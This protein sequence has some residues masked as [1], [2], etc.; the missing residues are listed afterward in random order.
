MK[1]LNFLTSFCIIFI[2]MIMTAGCKA[3]GQGSA[4]VS[5]GVNGGGAN[6]ASALQL[7][8]IPLII[9][10]SS[11]NNT[12][13]T[14]RVVDNLGNPVPDGAV[15]NFSFA[16]GN[17][18]KASL[19]GFSAT[20]LGG[21]AKV[22]VTATTFSNAI[23]VVN[24]SSGAASGSISI[25]IKAGAAGGTVTVAAA[26]ANITVTGTSTI[27]ATVK[28]LLGNTVAAGVNVDFSLNNAN[29]SLSLTTV[30][31]NASGQAQTVLTG[32]ATPN[33]TVT[34]TVASMGNIQGAATVTINPQ[35]LVPTLTISSTSS[36]ILTFA[37]TTVDV[38]LSGF[39]PLIGQTVFF[40]VDNP[41]VVTLSAASA[42][43]DVTGRASITLTA[44]GVVTSVKVTASSTVPGPTVLNGFTTVS[45]SSAP[46]D[47]VV[48]IANPPG[49]TVF[50][51][52]TLSA[53]VTGN[54]NTVP[55][56]TVVNFILSNSANGSLS[57]SNGS[58]VNG[59]ATTTFIATNKAGSVSITAVAGSVSS[60]PATITITPATT[61]S[62]QFVSATPQIIGLK[63]SGN[64]VSTVVFS[65]LDIAGRIVADGTQ[66]TF[67]LAA[68]PGG[69]ACIVGSVG[70][71]STTS[72]I[73]STVS[74]LARVTL[75]SGSTAGPV[76][77]IATTTP[78][79]LPPISTSASEIS[80]GGGVVSATHF[81]LAT[82]QFNLPGFGISN[83]QANITAYVADRFG[84]F[85]ILKGTTVSFQT[86]AGAIDRA[87]TTDSTGIT[88]PPVV[89]RTQNP[90]PQPVKI[91]P[92]EVNL[93]NYLNR[94]Y[95]LTGTTTTL[96]GPNLS[97]DT[98]I[99]VADTSAFL[100]SGWITIGGE[101]ILYT[102]T[103]GLSFTGCT[104]GVFGTTAA[105]HP[106]LSIV[107]ELLS[108]NIPID[109]SAGHPRNGLVTVLATVPG[110]EAFSDLNGN[111][112][113]DPGEPFVDIGEPL[114]DRNGDGCW[115]KGPIAN[116]EICGILS[117][118]TSSTDPF[119][120]YT[121]TNNNGVWDPPNGVWDGPGCKDAG[122]QP[123][124][125]IWDNMT[126]AFTGGPSYCSITPLSIGSMPFG[127]SKSFS[128]MVGDANINALIPGT[129]IVAVATAGTLVGET[130]FTLLDGVP[131]GPAETFFTLQASACSSPPCQP[132]PTSI[133]ITVTPPNS[134]GECI[135]T[136][137]GIF[138]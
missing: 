91:L 130:S 92:W 74:G 138:N 9:D 71:C 29:G 72:A 131:H 137:S 31:T 55:D 41:G 4:V 1:K 107:S 23:V 61:G 115:N 98:I 44:K 64:A 14:A 89:F 8:A 49:I 12:V 106:D 68:G 57:S 127:S 80:I 95:S 86:D 84:N 52:S 112:L 48:L 62:I 15:V 103:T 7:T 38:T 116:A 54:S 101:A 35:A 81:T 60:S 58:T 65:V 39:V 26:P 75:N 43:T 122:C 46:P 133:T 42:V 124:K 30:Q 123:S 10:L 100:S 56:G 113:Y 6:N 22:T 3:G 109:G 129:T 79:G 97:T 132:V 50:G 36:S 66:V 110:E 121:D 85:N 134:F 5:S 67:T 93:I 17:Q 37:T 119:E 13:V 51:T 96:S 34:A 2:V 136:V 76:T 20:T 28:D 40:S 104:R 25:T 18:L 111:G 102:G 114:A 21:L 117:T 125:L 118:P 90:L 88:N 78:T 108:L 63:G 53:L 73:G 128:F 87:G 27:T 47:N 16:P 120:L 126:L 83:A 32:I 19:S 11:T 94:T 82:S 45:I 69:G 24:A 99:T 135:R 33:V 59:I 105:N 77:I 70:T